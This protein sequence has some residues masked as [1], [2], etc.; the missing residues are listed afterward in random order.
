M[1]SHE[2]TA[3]EAAERIMA[4]PLVERVRLL[5]G[6][7]DAGNAVPPS[8]VLSLA[9]NVMAEIERGGNELSKLRSENET[10]RPLKSKAEHLDK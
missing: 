9:R 7:I 3:Q 6:F 5:A 8:L 2:L 10:L 1:T 4:L